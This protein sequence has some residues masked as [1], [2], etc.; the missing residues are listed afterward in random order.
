MSQSESDDPVDSDTQNGLN[1]L[2]NA[3]GQLILDPIFLPSTVKPLKDFQCHCPS[4][5]I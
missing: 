4:F 1:F 5:D 2:R 3:K